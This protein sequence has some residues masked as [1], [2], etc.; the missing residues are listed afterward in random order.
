[1]STP[2]GPDSS[3]IPSSKDSPDETALLSELISVC[4][5]VQ[6]RLGPSC[7]HSVYIDSI[8]RELRERGIFAVRGCHSR[9][10]SASRTRPDGGLRLLGSGSF[11]LLVEASLA[12]E[13]ADFS[14][15]NFQRDPIH[16]IDL[17][18]ER[19][20]T[21]RLDAGLLVDFNQPDPTEGIWLARAKNAPSL[22]PSGTN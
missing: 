15:P 2:I 18:S 16:Q 4:L 21:Q 11:D 20:R 14:D 5:A 19:L 22:S 12:L 8:V 9:G 17:F 6:T 10:G 13:L 7:P 3:R 1:M